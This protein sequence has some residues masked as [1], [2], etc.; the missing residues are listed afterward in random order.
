MPCHHVGKKTND[1]AAGLMISTPANSTGIKDQFNQERNS[2]RPE[3]M[4]PEMSIGTGQD[5][6]CRND[7]HYSSESRV[8]RYVCR[9]RNQ[10]ENII[11]QDKKEYR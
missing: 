5:H 11:D 9:S 6:H 7:S 1:N 10:S 4:T 8:T 2:G 3:D